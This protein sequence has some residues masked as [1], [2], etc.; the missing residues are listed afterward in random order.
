[1]AKKIYGAIKL[2]KIFTI[3]YSRTKLLALFINRPVVKMSMNKYC[4]QPLQKKPQ[5]KKD[6]KQVLG[7]NQKIYVKNVCLLNFSH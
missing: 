4:R 6:N 1:V 5:G 3:Y 7:D 2:F